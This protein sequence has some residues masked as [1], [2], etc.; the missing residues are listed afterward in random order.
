MEEIDAIVRASAKCGIT[1]VRVTGGEPLVRKGI[2]DI[3]RNAGATEGINELCLTTNGILLPKYAKE[4]KSAGVSRV[5]L[6]LDTLN[7]DK[8]KQIT[9]LGSLDEAL[10]GL[11]TALNEFEKVKINAVL[12]G[13]FNDN[14][15]T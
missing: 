13:G 1:K 2:I 7:A 9:R 15:I 10:M 11:K 8:Y 6:S 3:C 12:I 5:N 4:L 14:E